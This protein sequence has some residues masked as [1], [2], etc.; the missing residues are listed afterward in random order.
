MSGYKGGSL[1]TRR[2]SSLLRDATSRI[3]VQP[4]SAV[5]GLENVGEGG[6]A[7]PILCAL[8]VLY[9]PPLLVESVG[10]TG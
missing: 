9:F 8:R 5:L 6:C 4:P 10:W 3:V 7:D 2:K 1:L